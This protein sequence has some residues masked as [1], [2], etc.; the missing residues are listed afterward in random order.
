MK[1]PFLLIVMAMACLLGVAQLKPITLEDAILR[2]R[3]TL[4]P[5]NMDQ[6]K[7]IPGTDQFSYVKEI[8]GEP[9]LFS[10]NAEGKSRKALATLEEVN[11]ALEAIDIG[12]RKRFPRYQYMD[13]SHFRFLHSN[14]VIIFDLNSKTAEAVTSYQQ[15]AR[16]PDLNKQQQMAYTIGQNMFVSLP[17]E[18]DRAVTDEESEYIRNG[19]AT[20]RF[21]FGIVQG[22]FWSPKGDKLAFYR[23]DETMVT[24]Y[25][26]LKLSQQPAGY[27]VIPY[28]FA[29]EKSHHATLGVYDATTGKTIFLQTGGDPE[30]YLTNITWSPDG[31]DIYIQELNRDQ[32]EMSLNRYDAATGLREATLF[33][34]KHDKYVHPTHGLTFLPG[35]NDEF[36]FQ[37]QRDGYNHLYHYKTDGTL[38]NQ[39]TKGEFEVTQLHG[40][41]GKGKEVYFTGTT[42]TGIGRHLMRAS[43]KKG[44][45]YTYNPELE[46]NH[47]VSV[48]DDC[49]YF[50]DVYSSHKVPRQISIRS[51]KDGSQVQLLLDADNP[52]KDYAVG[53]MTLKKIKAADGKTDL[54][55]RMVT[56]PDFDPNKKYPALVYVYNGPGVQIIEDRWG[57]GAPMWM[58]V[59]ASE[60]LVV[61]SVDGRGS[62]NR[63]LDFEQ[64]IF[65]DLGTVEIQ[66]Q[67]EGVKYLKSLPYIDG[68]RLGVHGWSYGGFMTTA[69][70]TREPGTFKVGVAGG[71]VIDWS[72]YE[73]MYTERYM[74]TPQDNPE[75][76]KRSNLMQYA[77][78]LEGKL[79][80]IHGTSDD[81]VVWQHSLAYIEECVD[82]GTQIDYFVYPN[83][84]HNVRGKDRIHLIRKVLDYIQDHN[85]K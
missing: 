15:G 71:P 26:L 43:L 13:A 42:N 83:H 41:D 27:E 49:K 51:T 72:L 70:M 69:L 56:P 50:I 58:H 39:V 12:A 80:L 54:W 16:N 8:D 6:L 66:D 82:V 21:E 59:A 63:G 48:T 3:T 81:I 1:K 22:T 17:G 10:G 64:A 45:L 14:Q 30:H 61:F 57:A 24:L 38:L 33:T 20:H 76:F 18:P 67:L 40:F 36:I 78:D 25:P 53:N 52:L 74:D 73:V 4:A 23:A 84:P 7:W 34:D 68:D 46:G 47:R 62:A 29:G 5:E 9:A 44:E 55:T 31:K 60:G 65:R 77:K 85:G 28:P 19:E 35:K 11:T 32:N 75:G 2:T 79:L 37:S